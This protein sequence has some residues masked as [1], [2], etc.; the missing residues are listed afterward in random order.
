MSVIYLPKRSD[1][2]RVY[3][4]DFGDFEEI[5]GGQTLTGTPT[6]TASPSGLTL[7]SATISGAY[8]QV[9]VSSGSSTEGTRYLLNCAV[10]TSGGSTLSQQGGI[11]M[12][13]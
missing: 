5:R 10:S 12:V 9:Q 7:A 11:V 2:V 13:A 3:Q 4:F 8:V 1:W 6:V